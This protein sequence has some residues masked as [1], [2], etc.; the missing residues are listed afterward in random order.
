M[1]EFGDLCQYK[2]CFRRK[3]S[4]VERTQERASAPPYPLLPKLCKMRGLDQISV[5]KC[6]DYKSNIHYSHDPVRTHVCKTNV[7]KTIP[8]I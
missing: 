5:F 7:H 1:A 4:L 8:L 3:T 2:L 6:F